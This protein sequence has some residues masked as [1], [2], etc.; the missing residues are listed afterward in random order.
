[1]ARAG[2]QK[3]KTT[4]GRTMAENNEK[5]KKFK[6]LDLMSWK[7]VERTAEMQKLDAEKTTALAQIMIEESIRAIKALGGK[8]NEEENEEARNYA[9]E[10]LKKTTG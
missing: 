2:N 6:G 8:T 7:E 10:Q 4:G 9:R 3:N 1:M 5:K